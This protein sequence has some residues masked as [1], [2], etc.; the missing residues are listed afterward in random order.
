MCQNSW[1][2]LIGNVG[3]TDTEGQLILMFYL[4]GASVLSSRTHPQVQN[5]PYA[6]KSES[7]SDT[8]DY[9]SRSEEIRL[10]QV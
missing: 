8:L 9:F 7:D 3:K 6:L 4:L 5:L 1:F 10:M 2:T